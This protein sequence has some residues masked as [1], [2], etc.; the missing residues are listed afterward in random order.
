MK[1]QI[2]EIIAA[3]DYRDMIGFSTHPQPGEYVTTGPQQGDPNLSRFIG[4]VVQVRK[5]AGCFGS[6]IILLR[7]PDGELGRHENQMFF[8][9]D[10][11]WLEKAKALYPEG[12]TPEEHEDY[13]KPYT[14]GEKFPET[15]KVIEPNDSGPIPDNS[16]MMKITTTH[17]DGSKDITIV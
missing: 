3:R 14:L 15:G 10:G 16:P 1:E 8:R 17:A 4:Y 9:I 2:E 13:S 11:L 7:H 12:M 5:K 6:D